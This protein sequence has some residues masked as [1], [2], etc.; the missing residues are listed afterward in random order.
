MNRKNLPLLLMLFAGAVTCIVTYV[1]DYS[2]AAKLVSLFFV[3]LLFY[4]F[5][6]ILKW[7]LDRFEKQNEEKAKLEEQNSEMSEDGE[8]GEA[9]K[10]EPENVEIAKDA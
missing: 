9:E 4:V 3:L 1:M 5:G 7:T 2:V 10:N 8:M 6:S